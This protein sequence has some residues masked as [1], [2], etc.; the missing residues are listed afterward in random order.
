[1][2]KG[3]SVYTVDGVFFSE[4]TQTVYEESTQV[5][6]LMFRFESQLEKEAKKADCKDAL[7]SLA[8]WFIHYDTRLNC[9][10]SWAP[11]IKDRYLTRHKHWPQE[12]LDFADKHFVTVAKEVE[13]W[14]DDCG[15]FIFGYLVRNFSENVLDQGL[16]EE[17]IWVVSSLDRCMNV[18]KRVAD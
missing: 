5:I 7:R 1:M 14:M 9:H 11:E 12:E 4:D 15:L 10:Y 13:K 16:N 2:F 8:R 18:V 17:E 6:R 3:Y